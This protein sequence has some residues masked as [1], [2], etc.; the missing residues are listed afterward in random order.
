MTR[1]FLLHRTNKELSTTMFWLE[2]KNTINQFNCI[3]SRYGIL[4]YTCLSCCKTVLSAP[5]K[6]SSFIIL[7]L[8]S[9][10]PKHRVWDPINSRHQKL[11]VFK[12][13]RKLSYLNGWSGETGFKCHY[14][15]FR[16]RQ[17]CMGWNKSFH[18]LS[19][20]KHFRLHHNN[21]RIVCALRNLHTQKTCRHP[22]IS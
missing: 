11:F 2:D 17:F 10:I 21:F 4:I 22:R 6:F 20:S 15:V 13:D 7:A 16:S 19:S 8:L 1:P 18:S 12:Y 5:N 3:T 14:Q 9:R